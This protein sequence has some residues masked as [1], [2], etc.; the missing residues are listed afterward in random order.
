M[1]SWARI[2]T[3]MKPGDRVRVDAGE[4]GSTWG[5][6][7]RVL[8]GGERVEI[9][10]GKGWLIYPASCVSSGK[11]KPQS[12]RT[13]PT[14]KRVA[15]DGD[16]SKLKGRIGPVHP[17]KFD[18]TCFACGGGIKAGTDVQKCQHVEL[19]GT[20][21]RHGAGVWL[22]SVCAEAVF[23]TPIPEGELPL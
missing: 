8:D 7:R 14:T 5:V 4:L 6:V 2:I 13:A 1:R 17:A 11:R 16:V 18:G 15:N 23:P 9:G 3:P 20:R 10:H 12:R 19:T 21:G 22:H